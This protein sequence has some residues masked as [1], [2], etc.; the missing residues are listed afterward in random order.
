MKNIADIWYWILNYID[1][2]KCISW[3]I[4]KIINLPVIIPRV[5][6]S[7]RRACY[8]DESHHEW[9]AKWQIA[10]A[11]FASSPLRRR[12]FL[13]ANVPRTFLFQLAIRFDRCGKYH[14]ISFLSWPEH[15]GAAHP[16]TH[17]RPLTLPSTTL[18]PLSFTRPVARYK[19][20]E[21]ISS[22]RQL[23]IH[24]QYPRFSFTTRLIVKLYTLW[25]CILSIF[26][27]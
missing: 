25:Y 27:R 3:M 12:W 10:A 15:S 16:P 13:G 7:C 19:D 26:P 5:L 22:V 4:C 18:F 2:N 17:V 11:I 6:L 8:R 20:G 1:E 14:P 9:F 24:A 23:E 21:I